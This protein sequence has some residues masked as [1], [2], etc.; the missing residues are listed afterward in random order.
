[1][2][3]PVAG[4]D[5]LTLGD[6]LPADERQD[7]ARKAELTDAAARAR[8][9]LA[10]L[11]APQREVFELRQAGLSFVEIAKL[12]RVSIN[13]ALGRMHDAIRHLRSRL[14]DKEQG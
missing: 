2:E 6:T 3:S 11:H 8:H 5:T 12:Q 9:A 13:T 1:M 7:P 14:D 4:S 10:S